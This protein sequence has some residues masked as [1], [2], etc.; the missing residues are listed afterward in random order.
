MSDYLTML[1]QRTLEPS[2]SLRPRPQARF[3]ADGF[4]RELSATVL[5]RTPAGV[6]RDPTLGPSSGEAGDHT[7]N[8]PRPGAARPSGQAGRRAERAAAA[9]A[10]DEPAAGG[11]AAEETA[12]GPRAPES[13]LQVGPPAR[14]E[15]PER[16]FHRPAPGR[17]PAAAGS[18]IGVV[19]AA[20]P[21][22]GEGPTRSSADADPGSAGAVASRGSEPAATPARANAT[23][24]LVSEPR[25]PAR[26][27][28]VPR[29]EKPPQITVNIGRV[30]VAAPVKEPPPAERA[31]IEQPALGLDDYL[32][33]RGGR[34]SR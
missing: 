25:A 3:E 2:R 14:D 11:P 8:S 18:R 5:E 12:V 32:R 10:R 7:E 27:R 19:A 16:A 21:P 30:Q 13:E 28:R 15:S 29:D 1:V 31:T 6:R 20:E 23:P 4:G 17:V 26:A 34:S 22:A 9:G 33:T 24:S